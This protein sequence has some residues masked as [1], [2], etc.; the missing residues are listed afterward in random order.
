MPYTMSTSDVAKKMPPITKKPKS[1]WQKSMAPANLYERALRSIAKE[2]GR[3]TNGYMLDDPLDPQ[4]DQSLTQALKAYSEIIGP[5]CLNLLNSVIEAV[6]NQD[7]FAWRQH[8]KNMSIALRK[9]LLE[10]PIGDTVKNIFSQNLLLIKSIPIQAAERVHKLVQENMMQSTR[11]SDLAK[12]IM[13]TEGVAKSR[14]TLIARTEVS[15]A[16]VALTRAR[17]EYVGSEGYVW[18]TAGD[19]VVRKSHRAMNGKYCEWK[20]PP[21]IN[22]GSDKSPNMIAHGPGEIWNCRCYPDVVIPER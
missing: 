10:A 19:L 21:L 5:W 3:I 14:A 6:D 22:E 13:E 8:S 9:E 18:R 2:V 17:A 20:N 4:K 15:K 12:M 11:S 16:S 7:K 1:P